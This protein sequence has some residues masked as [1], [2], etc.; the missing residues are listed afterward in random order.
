MVVHGPRRSSPPG[1]EPPSGH[2][3]PPWWE[4]GAVVT[5]CANIVQFVIKSIQ[6]Y[7]NLIFFEKI[8]I[9]LN[10]SRALHRI[11]TMKVDLMPETLQVDV[12]FFQGSTCLAET[13][14][15]PPEIIDLGGI[16]TIKIGGSSRVP[17]LFSY[18]KP[19]EIA[20]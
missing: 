13:L 16:T 7:I 14:D 19:N 8:I 4:M 2:T 1:K 11:W 9:L 17:N 15:T 10:I 20:D 3:L 12:V 18:G 6:E 5:H